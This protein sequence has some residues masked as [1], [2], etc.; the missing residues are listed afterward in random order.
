M[1]T[2]ENAKNNTS[3]YRGTKT[4]YKE[5]TDNINITSEKNL[6][7]NLRPGK[8]HDTEVIGKEET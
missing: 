5:A 7:D 3:D 8:E 1:L 6:K 2:R 4:T